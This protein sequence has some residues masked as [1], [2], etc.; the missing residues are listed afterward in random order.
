MAGARCPWTSFSR[1]RSR[2]RRHSQGPINMEGR[3]SSG[4]RDLATRR[5]ALR[6]LLCARE[7]C[8]RQ[9]WKNTNFPPGQKIV[10]LD[11]FYRARHLHSPGTGS[12]RLLKN[13]Y[14]F[15]YFQDKEQN[16][17]YKRFV[18]DYMRYQDTIQCAA[19]RVLL[20]L[21]SMNATFYAIHARRND[22]QYRLAKISATDIIQNLQPMR[23]PER[24]TVFLATDDPTGEC[25]GCL[26]ERK[27]C[28]TYPIPRDKKMGCPDDPSW[29]AFT[30]VRLAR[31]HAPR[32]QE[33]LGDLNPNYYGMVD[34]I[35]CSRAEKW[36]GAFGARFRPSS[37]DCGATTGWAKK[38]TITRRASSWICDNHVGRV[39]AGRATGAPGGRTT[40]TGSS[41]RAGPASY[42]DA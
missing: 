20:K 32:F 10:K 9:T 3:G 37:I 21:R 12:H 34:Q 31:G 26:Y 22:F 24:V 38:V 27:P 41:S 11:E 13:F 4:G 33:E 29:N 2:A 28:H 6:H 7:R 8:S 1:K 19:H 30:D 17:F 16:R 23:Y 25:R 36:A 39:R 14:S 15:L 40:T 18:R 5:A 35:V 42:M